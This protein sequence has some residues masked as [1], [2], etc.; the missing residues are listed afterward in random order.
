LATHARHAAAPELAL[1]DEGF[2]EMVLDPIL[3]LRHGRLVH[4]RG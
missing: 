1:E 4:G 2:A 3:E